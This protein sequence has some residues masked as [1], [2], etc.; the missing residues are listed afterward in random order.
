MQALNNNIKMIK[1]LVITNKRLLV[2]QV[3]SNNECY[4][5]DE[6][7]IDETASSF[8]KAF[9]PTPE[10]QFDQ[11]FIHIDDKEQ[12]EL[13]KLETRLAA[14]KKERENLQA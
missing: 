2:V 6:S 8:I 12:Q 7:K 1:Q 5:I 3:I 4:I 13:E 9:L 11:T 10:S 14:F